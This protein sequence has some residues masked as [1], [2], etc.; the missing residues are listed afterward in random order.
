M[1][2]SVT[3]AVRAA[4]KST[5]KMSLVVG[6]GTLRRCGTFG[7]T[8]LPTV[9]PTPPPVPPCGPPD[10]CLGQ[11]LNSEKL[12]IT[13][14]EVQ[15]WAGAAGVVPKAGFVFVTVR[16]RVAVRADE[17]TDAV[18]YPGTDWRV[19]TNNLV[20]YTDKEG[21]VREPALVPAW[22]YHGLVYL[23]RPIEAG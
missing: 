19:H 4:A 11:S 17:V 18:F 14:L 5:A 15:P 13:P 22:V 16:V 12:T 20:W 8:A 9:A 3:T 1:S 21:G 2:S 10:L 7:A 6:G 23:D